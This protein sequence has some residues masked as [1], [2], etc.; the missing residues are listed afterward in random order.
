VPSILRILLPY[1]LTV[2]LVIAIYFAYGFGVDLL[3]KAL[4][5]PVLPEIISVFL[6][7]YLFTVE[8]RLLGL[9]YWT[10]RDKLRWF[11]T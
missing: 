1:A 6:S 9:L 5:I 8:M 4:P 11:R 3:Q 10:K 2:L 7:L